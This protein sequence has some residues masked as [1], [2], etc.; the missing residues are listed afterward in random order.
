[1][2]ASPPAVNGRQGRETRRSAADPNSTGASA[3]RYHRAIDSGGA[4][5][6]VRGKAAWIVPAALVFACVAKAETQ[7]VRAGCLPAETAFELT[8]ANQMKGAE[9]RA[10]LPGK[11]VTAERRN[12][13]GKSSRYGFEFRA[14]GSLVFDCRNMSGQPCRN[15]TPGAGARDI[16][17][18][19][20]D[21]DQVVLQR[22][23]FAAQGRKD[24]RVTFHRQ[25]GV[26]AGGRTSAPHFCLAGPILLE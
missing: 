3:R 20:I 18:W 8:P 14:D 25:G 7:Q 10:F 23:R 22:T 12:T 1:M 9:L 19:R 17:V 21:G 4:V 15:F 2:T 16:G 24:G 6:S 26:Y 13:D 5:T 11:H